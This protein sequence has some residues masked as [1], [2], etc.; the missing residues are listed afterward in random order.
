MS[1]RRDIENLS[2]LHRNHDLTDEERSEREVEKA[3]LENDIRKNDLS[4]ALPM[5]EQEFDGIMER[6]N[7]ACITKYGKTFC[8]LLEE[9]EA[10]SAQ[11][12]VSS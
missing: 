3:D 10:E 7:Q 2:F 9:G 1:S 12:N 11:H 6:T 8:E 4:S 5:S